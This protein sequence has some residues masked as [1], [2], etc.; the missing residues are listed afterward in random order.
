M[1][2]ASFGHAVSNVAMQMAARRGNTMFG[3]NGR[4]SKARDVLMWVRLM[5]SLCLV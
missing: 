2:E 4:V 1:P 5:G 3:S